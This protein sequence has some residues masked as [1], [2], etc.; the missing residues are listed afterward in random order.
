M[1]FQRTSLSKN[2]FLWY[3]K[4]ES[5]FCE[6][7]SV[8]IPSERDNL[9]GVVEKMRDELRQLRRKMCIRDRLYCLGY[10]VRCFYRLLGIR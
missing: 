10:T 3:D 1:Y 6:E 7:K 5:Y 9:Q 4:K 2:I 8:F